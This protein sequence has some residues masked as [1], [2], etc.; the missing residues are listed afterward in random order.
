MSEPLRL[1]APWRLAFIEAPKRS[2]CIFCDYP[3]EQGE[4]AD[5]RNLLVHRGEAA[6]T[7]LNRYPYNSGHVMVV[8]RRHVDRLEALAPDEFAALH[9][10][11]ALAARVVR[12]AYRPEGMNVGMNLGRI[13]GAG[14]ADHLHYHIVP[15][16]GGDTNFMPVLS[17]VRVMVEHLDGTWERLRRGFAAA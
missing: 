5:R 15:R 7:I 8:P 14:I 13:A 6:F 16:W 2:G 1:W 11:L 17:D 4:E 10:E 3:A 12:E 9:G